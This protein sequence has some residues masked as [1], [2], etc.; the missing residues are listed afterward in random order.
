MIPLSAGTSAST[1]RQQASVTQP[2]DLREISTKISLSSKNNLLDINQVAEGLVLRLIR[3]AWS[4]PTMRSLN[5][6]E[7]K[8]YPGIDLADDS[9]RVAIQVTATPSMAKIKTALKTFLKHNLDRRYGRLVF[10]LITKKQSRYSSK[11]LNKICGDRSNST[12]VVM[13][14]TSVICWG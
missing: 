5:A 2:R 6:D 11:E 8:N 3:I 14:W 1:M 4:N 12:S 13:C 9:Q 7:K 10:V